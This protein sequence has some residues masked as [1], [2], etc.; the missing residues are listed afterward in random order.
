MYLIGLSE[1]AERTVAAFTQAQ[2]DAFHEIENHLARSL[3]ELRRAAL[4]K[5]YRFFSV[6]GFRYFDNR[7]P[8]II[9]FEI[10]QPSQGFAVDVL[11]IYLILSATARPSAQVMI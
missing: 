5:P 11:L 2:A 9:L 7:F 8:F 3:T 6:D 4:V 1:P 10:G